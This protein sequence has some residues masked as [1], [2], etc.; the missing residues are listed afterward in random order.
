[1]TRD[2]Q[3]SLGMVDNWPVVFMAASSEFLSAVRDL[4]LL[5]TNAEVLA[6]CK[7][8]GVNFQLAALESLRVHLKRVGH[9][10]QDLNQLNAIHIAGTKGKGSTSIFCEAVLQRLPV[11]AIPATRSQELTVGVYTSP[12][13][14]EVR[15]RIR[16]NG[17]P[18]SRT[19]FSRYFYECWDRAIVPY[20]DATKGTYQPGDLLRPGYFQFLTLLAY[21]VF[22]SERVD[23]AVLEV[24]M[25]G[26][27]DAT[28]LVPKPTVC[29]ITSLGLDHQAVLG[30]TLREI[31][32][33]KAGIAK[34][35][36]PLLTVTQPPDATDAIVQAANEAATTVT[37]P[38]SFTR[39]TN[40]DQIHVGIAGTHQRSNAEL[41]V[42]LVLTW[43]R[44]SP[45]KTRLPELSEPL[46]QLPDFVLQGVAAAR[47]PGRSQT[48][49][50]TNPTITWHLDGAH[51]T[52]SIDAC[53]TWFLQ[54]A[55]L[56]EPT[57]L[58]FNCSRGRQGSD[59]LAQLA[60]ALLLRRVPIVAAVFC[61]NIT[62]R[63]DGQNHTVTKH[64]Q[65]AEPQSNAVAWQ[66][67]YNKASR[68]CTTHVCLS[69]DRAVAWIQALGNPAL[70]P[71]QVL[72][73][74]SLHLVGGVLDIVQGSPFISDA[75]NNGT[76]SIM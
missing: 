24:G 29:G 19:L 57:V 69:I 54:H 62:Q 60:Q 16:L 13:L 5:Q 25:G 7:Q 36:V 4:N 18:I 51:T 34:A 27:F 53:I 38:P 72:V 1:M 61:P 45:L 22:L 46:I 50:T 43:L 39:Y 30:N 10:V 49:V 71:T 17:R 55:K 9:E 63:L 56:N 8:P 42:A 48:V 73:T 66:A 32:Y 6:K 52:E 76:K 28:N 12:H 68:S 21:H 11:K 26:R 65:L 23:V 70:T 35:R 67:L 37:C 2:Y 59:M 64:Q 33:Q 31:A 14:V 58:L 40:A 44:Q 3:A 20:Q 74:G 47:W 75:V 15:E 41:A